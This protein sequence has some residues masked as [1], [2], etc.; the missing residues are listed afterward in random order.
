MPQMP[1][2]LLNILEMYN[3]KEVASNT[4]ISLNTLRNAIKDG[5]LRSRKIGREYKC[6]KYELLKFLNVDEND[7]LGF[8]K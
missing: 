3:L 7:L 2:R 1:K 8:S 5:R 6:T 4:G